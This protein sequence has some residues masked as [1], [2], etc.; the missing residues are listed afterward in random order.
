MKDTLEL[1][2][3]IDQSGSMRSL[4]KDTIGGFNSILEK[5]RDKHG[6]D[7]VV[8]TVLFNHETDVIHNR[9][10]IEEIEPLDE[11]QYVVGGTTALLDAVG[12]AI[13]HISHVH[14]LLGVKDT[15]SNTLF[16]ITTDGH[17]NASKRFKKEMIE[18]LIKQKQEDGWEFIFL[19]ANIDAYNQARSY[20]IRK[21][22]VSNYMHDG[23]GVKNMY[24][25]LNEAV[26]DL[27]TSKMMK[28]TWKQK[29]EADYNLRKKK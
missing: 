10:P 2:F 28:E 8:S 13:D 19:G 18:Y 25:S 6:S 12:G 9:I 20:G 5:Q 7:V 22:R 17:E 16:V 4:E 24:E 1:V 21:E 26:H 11:R 15:P 23:E 27:R 29:V 3:I 14:Q